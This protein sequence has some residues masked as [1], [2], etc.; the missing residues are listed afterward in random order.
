MVEYPALIYKNG[1][2]K[3]YVANC[4]TKNLFGFGKTEEDALKSLK[5]SL[6][7]LNK[8]SEISLKPMHGII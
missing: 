1:R 2:D 4:M 5:D 3:T 8:Q 6:Q 7:N